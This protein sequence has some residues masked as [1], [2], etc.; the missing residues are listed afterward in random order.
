MGNT[1]PDTSSFKTDVRK[2]P[3]AVPPGFCTVFLQS[4]FD[5]VSGVQCD[6]NS[7]FVIL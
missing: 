7:F 1:W 2:Q 6:R 5:I 3:K 4:F